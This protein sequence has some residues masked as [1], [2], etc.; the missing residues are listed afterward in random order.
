MAVEQK[1]S[2]EAYQITVMGAETYYRRKSVENFLTS[3]TL[4]ECNMRES[5][6]EQEYMT[7]SV[8]EQIFQGG[9]HLFGGDS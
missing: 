3:F 4:E 1:R 7:V 5:A 8:D 6:L 2:L 9:V